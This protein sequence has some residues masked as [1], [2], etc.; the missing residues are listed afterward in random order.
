MNSWMRSAF[1]VLVTWSCAQGLAHEALGQSAV[2]V[3]PAEISAAFSNLYRSWQ[4]AD[5]VEEGIVL[6]EQLLAAEPSLKAWPLQAA[7]SDVRRELW[8]NLGYAYQTRSSGDRAGNLEKAVAA[9]QAALNLTTQSEQPQEWSQIQNNLGSALADRLSGD[10]G[11]NLERAIAAFEAALSVRTKA[12]AP[13]EWAQTQYSLAL[14]LADRVRGTRG[15]NMD[16][17]IAA[18]EMV[19]TVRT[20]EAFPEQWAEI[21]NS[22]GVAYRNRIFWRPGG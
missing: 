19:L 8:F 6:A 20:R 15:D 17:A 22:L 16:R 11:D 4:A 7:R 2:D 21:Q 5:D 9:Y 3:H 1:V 14:A 13:E 10:R 12:A 18:L